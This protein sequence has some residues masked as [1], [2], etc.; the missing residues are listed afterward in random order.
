MHGLLWL[1]ESI[2]RKRCQG[3]FSELL[4]RAAAGEEILIAKAGKPVARLVPFETSGKRVLG[5]DRGL[6]RVPEDFDAPPPGELRELVRR[7]M[8]R[9]LVRND[10][11][12]YRTYE[13][14]LAG[15]TAQDLIDWDRGER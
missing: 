7:G 10:P 8:A 5:Q 12:V 9:N 13:P 6:Y 15:V 2:Q 14:A 4:D 3:S 1:H 11:S